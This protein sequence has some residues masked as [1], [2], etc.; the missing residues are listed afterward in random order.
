MKPIF[1]TDLMRAVAALCERRLVLIPTETKYV[2]ACN[3]SDEGSVSQLMSVAGLAGH[4]RPEIFAPSFDRLQRFVTD[5]PPVCALLADRLTPGL[6]SFLLPARYSISPS[7]RFPDEKISIRVPAHPLTQ[8]LLDM[9]MFPLAVVS[10]AQGHHTTLTAEEAALLVAGQVGYVLDGGPA[11]VG[12]DA[13]VISFEPDAIVIHK[14]G[15]VSARSLEIES[16]MFVVNSITPILPA[17]EDA[18]VVPSG[19]PLA[20]FQPPHFLG[21]QE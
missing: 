13:T 5:I 17:A 12:S 14:K 8:S 20:E 16:E 7:L 9:C 11:A 15:A 6:L 21:I 18:M 10:M 1:G 3:A 2:L 19:L 4:E